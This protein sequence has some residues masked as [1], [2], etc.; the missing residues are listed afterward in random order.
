MTAHGR[1]RHTTGKRKA[2]KHKAGAHGHSRHGSPLAKGATKDVF[3][4]KA[5]A[6]GQK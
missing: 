3:K 6:K 5:Q 1:S 4:H 2:T